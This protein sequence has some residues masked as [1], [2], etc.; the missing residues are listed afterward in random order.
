[1]A[2]QQRRSISTKC[3]DMDDEIPRLLGVSK[4]ILEN[5]IFCHQ[6]ESNWPLSEPGVLKKK[7]D[8]IFEATKYTKALDQIKS[9]RKEQTAEL[10][11]DKERLLSYK[12]DRE[13]AAKLESSIQRLEKDIV[14]KSAQSDQLD[15]VI[16]E[17]TAHNKKFYELA[18]EHTRILSEVEN[19]RIRKEEKERTMEDLR[20]T[21]TE[22]PG[23]KQELVT[24]RDNFAR[25]AEEKRLKKRGY[26]Q[27]LDTVEDEYQQTRKRVDRQA[28]ERGRLQGEE[29]VRQTKLFLRL[30]IDRGF[31]RYEQ[32][33]DD[34]QSTVTS[35]AGQHDI[36]GYDI[37]NLEEA[38]VDEF[39]SRL[40]S[41][42]QKRRR[43]LAELVEAGSK[44]A[45]EFRS[46]IGSMESDQRT[47]NALRQDMR[48][49]IQAS[50]KRI[51][52]LATR[53]A[54]ARSSEAEVANLKQSI[55]DSEKKRQTLVD[56]SK[57][58]DLGEQLRL[59]GQ[60]VK[61]AEGKRDQLHA[62]LAS[63]NRQADTR[64]K[65]A[66]KRAEVTKGETSI[67]NM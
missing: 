18:V 33:L 14:S 42:A 29:Q 34:R 44:A 39:Q 19:L 46:K 3:S 45:D 40:S 13:R 24:K 26:G 37:D 32:A 7:F 43:A 66:I 38:K 11:V 22:L 60:A 23:T 12:T 48:T 36:K 54:N 28:T 4:A 6:E 59:K 21:I 53:I 17:V 63:L 30:L 47:N 49:Q 55:S 10:K 67:K 57:R 25:D 52:D 8:D 5:V 62:E 51:N 58:E 1:M 50:D 16:R 20:R 56:E 41:E 27:D 64:A 65:L 2:Y 35:L 31:Q 15:E 9:I 61:E